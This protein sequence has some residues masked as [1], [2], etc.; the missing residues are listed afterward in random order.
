[1]SDNIIPFRGLTTH[2]IDPDQVLKE[3]QGAL[4][5]VI[6]IGKDPEGIHY[7]ASSIGSEID[8]LRMIKSFE[9]LLLEQVDD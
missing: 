8:I 6:V 9:M 2:D 3:A 1:M 7:F 5:E 4:T